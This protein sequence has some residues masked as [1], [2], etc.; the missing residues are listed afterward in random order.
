MYKLRVPLIFAFLI[1]AAYSI[2]LFFTA[3]KALAAELSIEN[4][5]SNSS[6]S[7][8]VSASNNST[9]AQSNTANVNN[10]QNTQVDTGNN[11]ASANTGGDA[12][13]ATG[14]AAVDSSTT[15]SANLSVG[16][17]ND[18]CLQPPAVTVSGNGSGSTNN[19]DL[20]SSSNTAVGVNQ[21]SQ[22]TNSSTGT[23]NTGGNSADQNSGNIAI[24]SGDINVNE[25][26]SNKGVN[27]AIFEASTGLQN[28]ASID[29]KGNAADSN[30]NV[31]VSNN[32]NQDIFIT[33]NA[34]I[35]NIILWHKNT[36][37]NSASNNLWDVFI[38]TGNIDFDVLIDN[39][40]VNVSLV[41][42]GC[43]KQE[44]QNPPTGGIGEEKPP[45]G[46][47]EEKDREETSPSNP[48]STSPSSE[49]KP[50][51]GAVSSEVDN[52]IEEFAEVLGA[53]FPETGGSGFFNLAAFLVMLL[54]TGIAIKIKNHGL[55]GKS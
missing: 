34:L 55:Q 3:S 54:L 28:P 43:C 36:G 40:P 48:A 21:N 20:S 24:I 14:D 7:I 45:V 25:D 47:E 5:G 22:I 39:G 1:L 17:T 23:A 31:V 37:L 44:V 2:L 9:V 13:I 32:Q 12:T 42:V 15:T 46:N 29:I 41:R 35:E 11:S 10:E 52:P 30:T 18:C 53:S 27:V 6:S 19:V 50:V 16:Q 49:D 51:A 4:N 33:N 26:V 38:R 8:D